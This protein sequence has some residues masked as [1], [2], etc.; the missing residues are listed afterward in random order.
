MAVSSGLAKVFTGLG[1]GYLNALNQGRRERSTMFTNMQRV[2]SDKQRNALE[3]LKLGFMQEEA[4]RKA[5]ADSDQAKYQQ[6]LMRNSMLGQANTII[7]PYIKQA[8]ET[9]D[10]DQQYTAINTARQ[11]LKRVAGAGPGR[12]YGLSDEDIDGMLALPGAPMQGVMEKG[13][14]P[15]EQIQQPTGGMVG[16]I[17]PYSE[18]MKNEP[19]PSLITNQQAVLGQNK[20]TGNFLTGQRMNLTPQQSSM[21]GIYGPPNIQGKDQEDRAMQKAVWQMPSTPA[22]KRPAGQPFVPPTDVVAY[23]ERAPKEGLVP[24]KAKYGLGTVKS[25]NV[26]K[27]LA[28]VDLAR[29]KTKDI[30]E[31]MNPSI[32]LIEQKIVSMKASDATKAYLAQFAGLKAQI[33][34]DRLQIAQMMEDGRMTRWA[35]NLK[36]RGREFNFKEDSNVQGVIQRGMDTMNNFRTT[37]QMGTKAYSD[38]MNNGAIKP[39]DKKIQGKSLLDS[40]NETERMAG[41]YYNWITAE[42][43]DVG[44]I[45][46]IRANAIYGH[47][48]ATDFLK[49]YPNDPDAKRVYDAS[50]KRAYNPSAYAMPGTTHGIQY[51]Q[52]IGY[53]EDMANETGD[54]LLSNV[55]EFQGGPD[56]AGALPGIAPRSVTGGGARPGPS[57]MQPQKPPKPQPPKPPTPQPSTPPKATRPVTVDPAD[58]AN[59]WRNRISQ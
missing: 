37:I 17:L 50:A 57:P 48:L 54:Y 4:A 2:K 16:Q 44:E 29:A 6:G 55:P 49:R 23:G 34:Q 32:R 45:N 10:P 58:W 8:F 59:K 5:T 18:A 27:T 24:A 14:V 51:G 12:E 30:T 25:A 11:V 20:N 39:E 26:D 19:D 56:S 21:A 38:L 1:T 31:K 52:G 9:D 3:S 41:I 7:A 42:T 13:L 40:V 47:K 28:G 33:A 35:G 36:Q 15:G 46:A 43:G 22:Y 53:Q